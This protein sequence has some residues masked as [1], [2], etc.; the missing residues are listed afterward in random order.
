M[1]EVNRR[2]LLIDNESIEQLSLRLKRQ[3]SP[4]FVVIDSFQYTLITSR[5]YIEFKER[6]RNKPVSYTHLDVYKRQALHRVQA[7]QPQR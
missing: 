5:Q 2:F 6:H 4:N 1:M 7:E 3:K